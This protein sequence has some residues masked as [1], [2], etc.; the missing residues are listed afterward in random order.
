PEE[1][2][3]VEQIV[4]ESGSRFTR[5]RLLFLAGGAAGGTLGLALIT[6]AVSLGPVFDMD[7]FYETPWRQGRR[8][9][10]ERGRPLRA[11]DIEE[12]VF[13]TAYPE[14]ADR[15]QVGAPLVVVR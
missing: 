2:E 15:E 13:Y 12:A 1:Q 14:A 9:V 3:A 8:L 4:A 6:P 10:D 5:K 7:P 11:G